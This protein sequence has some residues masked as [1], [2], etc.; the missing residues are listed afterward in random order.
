MTRPAS[1]CIMVALTLVLAAGPCLLH[2]QQ[3]PPGSRL[4]TCKDAQGQTLTSDRPIPECVDREQREVRHT[5]GVL[6]RIEPTYT[7]AEIAEREERDRRA[8]LD[9]ARRL[10]EHRLVR[11]LF[12]RYPNPAAL[13]RERAEELAPFDEVLNLARQQL[14]ELASERQKIETELEFY[15]GDL[16]QA[17]RALQLRIEDNQRRVEA[18]GRFLVEQKSEQDRVRARFDDER[19]RLASLWRLPASR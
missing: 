11:A 18:Q 2:A 5:G 16:A 13:E 17:P 1:S 12:V 19:S 3:P 10:E 9:A 15:K 8:Q 7:A 4:Y 14:R 6:R